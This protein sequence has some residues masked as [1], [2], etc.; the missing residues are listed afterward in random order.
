MYII[1]LKPADRSRAGDLLAGHS[2]WLQQGLADGVFL[3][4]GSLKPDGGGAVLARGEDRAALERRVSADPFVAGGV[5]T[6]EV[7][8]IA[9]AHAV[10]ELDF[11]LG[12][13]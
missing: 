6:P 4:W 12:D 10:A 7:I 3:L 9:P 11:L 1:V 5:V 2:A 8:E 13:R